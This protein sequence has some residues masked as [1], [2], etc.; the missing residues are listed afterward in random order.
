M[1]LP[2]GHR[3][4][5]MKGPTQEK[6]L[7]AIDA[8]SSTPGAAVGGWGALSNWRCY[9]CVVFTGSIEAKGFRSTAVDERVKDKRQAS[10]QHER[11]GDH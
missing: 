3:R 8:A 9:L 2:L 10:R 4:S 5:R 1:E 7:Q 11:S 6:L